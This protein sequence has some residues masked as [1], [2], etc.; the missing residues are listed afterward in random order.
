MAKNEEV[1]VRLYHEDTLELQHKF[2]CWLEFLIEHKGIIAPS[3]RKAFRKSLS[4]ATLEVGRAHQIFYTTKDGVRIPL[5]KFYKFA[6]K[7]AYQRSKIVTITYKSNIY[8]VPI[9]DLWLLILDKV[10][11]VAPYALEEA[12]RMSQERFRF[13]AKPGVV[14]WKPGD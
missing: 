8:K 10:H 3:Y 7:M 11:D 6:M 9:E 14:E 5:G 2:I 12:R 13:Q 1:S 4:K